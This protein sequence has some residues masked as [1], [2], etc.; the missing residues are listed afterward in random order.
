[1]SKEKVLFISPAFFGYELS[2]KNAILENGYEV[3]Y[4]D[5]RP[6]NNA[7][8]KALVRGQKKLLNVILNKHFKKIQDYIKD[9]KYDYFLLIK[10]EVV[11]ENFILDFKKNN[12][13][14]KLIYYT[15]DA[16][17]NNSKNGLY[18][19]KFFDT[20]YSIDFNDVKENPNLK[21]KHLF[22]SK[23][24]VQQESEK[25]KNRKYDISFVGTLHSNRYEVMQKTFSK[26]KKSYLFLFS[27]AKWWFIYNKLINK[28]YKNIK[29]STISFTKLNLSEV[30]NIFK[31]SN[32]VLDIQRYGQAGLTMR[33][34]EVLAS[35]AI[36]VTTNENIKKAEF[37]DEDKIVLISDE[38][39]TEEK[40]KIIESKIEINNYDSSK[41]EKYFVNNW[42]KEFFT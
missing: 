5:E 2:I 22:Y 11:P 41:L 20:C 23:D 27:Q 15:Y 26:F 12:P 24:F 39:I 19:Q 16:S 4:F 40:V 3:D 30:A 29:M 8:M 9:K 32:S 21:L 28:E 25:T 37:Y 35:G 7:L 17:N 38:E 6:S 34:F 42:V 10:G 36:L 18:I 31:S 14:A 33:T 1:M 13:T